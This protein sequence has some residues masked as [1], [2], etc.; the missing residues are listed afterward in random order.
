MKLV[1]TNVISLGYLKVYLPLVVASQAQVSLSTMVSKALPLIAAPS[2][3]NLTS[4]FLPL[5]INL[6]PLLGVPIQYLSSMEAQKFLPSIEALVALPPQK[7]DSSIVALVMVKKMV[8][9]HEL[10][11]QQQQYYVK[12]AQNQ[13]N[14]YVFQSN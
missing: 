12:I 5:V 3:T 6:L 8:V 11:F 1:K 4:V 7:V 14:R 10:T 9:N 2:I 13:W